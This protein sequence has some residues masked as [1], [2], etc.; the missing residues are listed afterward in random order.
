LTKIY[1]KKDPNNLLHMI[2]HKSM[3]AEGRT[4]LCEPQEFIQCAA[5][6]PEKGTTY[7]P[8]QHKWNQ[9]GPQLKIAQESWVVVA[10][11]V[12][13]YFYDIDGTLLH[14]DLLA[15]G[16]ASFTFEGGHNYEIL[17]DNTFVYEYKTGP[18]LGQEFD[19]E[20]I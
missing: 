15:A 19:K 1:S 10:G 7:R 3:M 14:T 16:D 6:R 9:V 5:L 13:V 12:K 4:D 20:F 11:L 18:Y 17:A 2:V 8:H